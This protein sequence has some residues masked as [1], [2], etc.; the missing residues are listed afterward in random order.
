MRIFC[1]MDVEPY[2][3]AGGNPA[4]DIK[5]RFSE[6]KNG[7]TAGTQMAGLENRKNHK[8]CAELSR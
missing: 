4:I 1:F 7:K 2:S 6:D 5:K 3:I 8:E